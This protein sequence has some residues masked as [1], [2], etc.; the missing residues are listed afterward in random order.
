MLTSQTVGIGGYLSARS[1]QTL[2]PGHQLVTGDGGDDVS[3]PEKE[4]ALSHREVM[5]DYL[6]PLQ[7]PSELLQALQL[8]VKRHPIIMNAVRTKSAGIKGKFEERACSSIMIGLSVSLGYL[9]G[10]LL[11]L[12]PYF[13]VTDVGNG[14][15]W[16][17]AV[18]ILA[19]FLFGF[20]KT[21][22]L[23][24]DETLNLRGHISPTWPRIRCSLWEGVQMVVLGSVA[25]LVAVL[26]V[27]AFEGLN[28]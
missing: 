13:F 2:S 10:G 5:D 9:L 3:D 28:G 1:E 11:P 20:T 18:C 21:Y 19:L 12:F 14:L 7:L 15:R 27:R 25:A 17:F 4:P 6:A 26:A 23:Q 22:I 8:H 24:T 16:S